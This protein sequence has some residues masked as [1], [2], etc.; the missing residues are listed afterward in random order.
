MKS[1]CCFCNKSLTKY[2]QYYVCEH[3]KMVAFTKDIPSPE[4][5]KIIQ[6]F[7]ND[8]QNKI[9]EQDE[10]LYLLKQRHMSHETLTKSEEEIITKIE[11]FQNIRC[12]L[13]C[14][15]FTVSLQDQSTRML[16]YDLLKIST[17][18]IKYLN[19]NES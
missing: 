18:L 2:G 12:C 15:K 17:W 13:Q 16:L 19:L 6:K 11:K 9:M 5:W 1:E 7:L 14:D 4:K 10:S 3:C 8:V